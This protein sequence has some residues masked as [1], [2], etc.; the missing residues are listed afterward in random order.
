M[1]TL[2]C[3]YQGAINPYVAHLEQAT[4][5]WLQQFSLLRT[6]QEIRYN[7]EGKFS[8]MIARMFPNAAFSRLKIASDL[9][10]WL[11][12]ID[13]HWDTGIEKRNKKLLFQGFVFK[14][15]EIVER[16]Y[17]KVKGAVLTAFLDIWERLCEVSSIEWQH[18][19]AS[20]LRD[21]L[22]ANLWRMELID[23]CRLPT[24]EEYMSNRCM[25]GGAN[26][27]N[28][29]VE[30]MIDVNIPAHIFDFP[31]MQNILRY[32]ADSVCYANDIFSYQKELEEG[33][34]MNLVMILRKERHI[35]LSRA[36]DL[37]VTVHDKEVI[38]FEKSI[39]YLFPFSSDI[40]P[41]LKKYINALGVMM[42]G[43]IDWST[44]DTNRYPP[45]TES[46]NKI[47]G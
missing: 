38:L 46:I 19:F 16:P 27:F 11:F 15:I 32:C 13:D 6:E 20:S 14:L 33:D 40:D 1:P 7:R 23:Q 29:L 9:N 22:L 10:A 18:R 47:K 37:A 26:V 31:L 42:K 12:L 2:Y 36:L 4:H 5:D 35:T 39:R 24:L 3:P 30:I 34:E 17:V 8:H 25:I 43:N 28:H 44:L 41:I 45:A 21:A